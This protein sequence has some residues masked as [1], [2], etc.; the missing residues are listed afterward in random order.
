MPS[1]G[2][3]IT[4]PW[5]VEKKGTTYCASSELMADDG[6]NRPIKHTLC[7]GTEI[8]Q[9][10]K[11]ENRDSW[12]L[13]LEVKREN[14]A[15]FVPKGAEKPAGD[16]PV[17]AK[18][19][20]KEKN[21]IVESDAVKVKTNHLGTKGKVPENVWIP[22]VRYDE[23]LQIEKDHKKFLIE[24]LQFHDKAEGAGKEQCEH[25]NHYHKSEEIYGCW[26]DGCEGEGCGDC[27]DEEGYCPGCVKE[28]KEVFEKHKGK[29][30]VV[31]V[32][33]LVDEQLDVEDAGE[34]SAEE[35]EAGDGDDDGD[36]V[37]G[38]EEERRE[39]KKY[40]EF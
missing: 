22:K 9:N 25:C 32:K 2:D 29:A 20:K 30:G 37:E 28:M 4:Y 31:I 12:W 36:D 5:A 17:K 11:G 23:L 10:T 21:E 19:E 15:P 3:K 18:T 38:D 39:N 7:N 13:W 14:K 24:A 33:T 1:I 6:K 8:I 27:L 35:E 26:T 34:E 16:K 40:S